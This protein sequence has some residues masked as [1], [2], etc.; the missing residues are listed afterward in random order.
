MLIAN[1]LTK[2]YRTKEKKGFFRYQRKEVTAVNNLSFEMKPGK[3]IGLLGINGAGKTT[4]IKMCTTLLEPTS[5]SITIDGLDA[6]K[7]DRKV[8]AMVNMIAGGERML[9]WRLTGRENLEYFAALYGLTGKVMKE[10][11]QSVLHEVELEEAAHIPVERYSKGMKQRLQIARGLINDPKYLFLD[12]PTLGLDAPIAKH[13]RGY[14][15][16]LAVTQGKAVLLTSHYMHEVE[17]LCDEV[18][19]IDKGNVVVRDTPERLVKSMF[20]EHTLRVVVPHVP[21]LFLEELRGEL[22]LEARKGSLQ[23]QETPEANWEILIRT[24]AEVTTLVM[25]G[26]VTHRIPVLAFSAEQPGLEDVIL[27]LAGRQ[28]A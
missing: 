6:V 2:I 19:I 23:V 17:E 9:Y 27:H 21:D 18:L 12:E 3:I 10:R 1:Q 24:E 25:Q 14:V 11:I 5:G 26:L 8:K 22:E 20:K 13:L 28:T 16:N 7:E 15:K 4:T